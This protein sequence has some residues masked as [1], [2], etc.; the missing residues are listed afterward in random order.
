MTLIQYTFIRFF[1]TRR[2]F[3]GITPSEKIKAIIFIS[4]LDVL[5]LQILIIVVDLLFKHIMLENYHITIF[6]ILIG[7]IVSIIG[8][9][10]QLSRDKIFSKISKKYR[11]MNHKKWNTISNIYVVGTFLAYI[12]CCILLYNSN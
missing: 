8:R 11:K 6:A 2:N 12:F 10:Q 5:W 7:G 4:S 3:S 9:N 1:F